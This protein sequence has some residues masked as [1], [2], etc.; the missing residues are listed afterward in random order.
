M[1]S[2]NGSGVGIVL[3]SPDGKITNLS[4]S[5]RFKASNNKMEYKAILVGLRLVEQHDEK[6]LRVY[7]DSQLV[8]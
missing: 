5:F 8:A 4:L 3:T 6:N 7:C 1:F 2:T